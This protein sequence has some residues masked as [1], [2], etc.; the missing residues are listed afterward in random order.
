[1]GFANNCSFYEFTIVPSK[2]LPD[3]T[4]YLPLLIELQISF[5]A[6]TNDDDDDDKS[7]RSLFL[8]IHFFTINLN[9]KSG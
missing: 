1:M 3:D 8:Q 9:Y 5:G 4:Y 6:I 7:D 2:C